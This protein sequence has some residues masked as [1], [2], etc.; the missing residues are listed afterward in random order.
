MT[1]R[2]G[3]NILL[4]AASV[5]ALS[6]GM[7]FA[8]ELSVGASSDTAVGVDA[9]VGGNSAVGVTADAGIGADVG[10]GNAVSVDA[11]TGADAAVTLGIG[12]DATN[13]EDGGSV[14]GSAAAGAETD[15]ESD[16]R[17]QARQGDGAIAAETA[18][19]AAAGFG[20]WTLAEFSGKRVH[21]SSGAGIGTVESVAV[22]AANT[23]HL[24]VALDADDQDGNERVIP[25]D[26]FQVDAA[27]DALVLTEADVVAEAA[28]LAAAADAYALVESETELRALL[29]AN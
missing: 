15:A 13:G 19:S 8:G 2:N 11:D 26:R 9:S 17:L 23:V 25:L 28:G 6:C 29:S 10:A 21:D 12:G 20:A 27:A 4:Q 1:I 22:D 3:R 5:L 16:V 18:G 24:V 14:D 7:A